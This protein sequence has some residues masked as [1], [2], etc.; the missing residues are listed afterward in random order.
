[1]S[2]TAPE[3]ELGLMVP[4]TIQMPIEIY[5]RYKAVAEKKQLEPSHVMTSALIKLSGLPPH[6]ITQARADYANG[7]TIDVLAERYGTTTK[8][9]RGVVKGA[10]QR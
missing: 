4:V 9:M 7:V 3:S 1:M 8:Y 5:R 2:Y 10:R 6:I